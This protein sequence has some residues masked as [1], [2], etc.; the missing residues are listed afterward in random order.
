MSVQAKGRA[1][2]APRDG[3][4]G[5]PY[6]VELWRE[7]AIERVLAWAASAALARAIF[8]AAKSEHPDRRVTLRRGGRIIADSGG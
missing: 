4:A 5:L 1:S 6:R 7:R 3:D 8:K 2:A